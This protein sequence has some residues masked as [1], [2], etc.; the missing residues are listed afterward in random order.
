MPGG[1]LFVIA[2]IGGVVFPVQQPCPFEGDRR[3][4]DG[5]DKLPGPVFRLQDFHQ[6]VAVPEVGRPRKAARQDH[7]IVAA[8]GRDIVQHPVALDLHLVGPSH[9]RR[10]ADEVAADARPAEDIRH[11]QRLALFKAGRQKNSCLFHNCLL[12]FHKGFHL[13]CLYYT[14]GRRQFPA[15]SRSWKCKCKPLRGEGPAQ[16][17]KAIYW[18]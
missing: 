17:F 3:G 16:G 4:A 14:S 11:C 12:F 15:I 13:D 2:D 6:L 1:D 10:K 5:G 7:H 8:V 9:H 18:G